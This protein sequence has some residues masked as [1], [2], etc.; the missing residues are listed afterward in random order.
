M[1]T[2]AEEK[3]IDCPPL[4]APDAKALARRMGE[5]KAIAREKGY[6]EITLW[7]QIF[8]IAELLVLLAEFHDMSSVEAWTASCAL[9]SRR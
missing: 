2:A 7:E 9:V 6:F 4:R 1:T 8:R 5:L 3:N